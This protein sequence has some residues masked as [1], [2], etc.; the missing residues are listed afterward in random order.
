[1]E[2]LDSEVVGEECILLLMT[3][4]S[5]AGATRKDSIHKRL[6]ER[7]GILLVQVCHEDLVVVDTEEVVVGLAVA[8]DHPTHLEAS[9]KAIS[10]DEWTVKVDA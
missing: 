5:A 4:F 2:A 3:P 6:Q 9:V 1:M 10:Y 7:D 8:V